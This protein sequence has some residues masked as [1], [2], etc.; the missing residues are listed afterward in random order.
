MA[1]HIGRRTFLA[2]LGGT[3]AWPLAARAQQPAMPVIGFLSGRSPSESAFAVMAFRQGL[4]EAGYVEGRNMHIAFRWAEGR[5]AQLPALAAELVRM[6]IAVIVTTGGTASALAAKA[7]TATIPV[8]FN[9]TVDP[10]QLG[11]VA[12][13]NRPGGNVTGVTNLSGVLTVKRLGLLRDLVPQVSQIA[14]LVNPD[15]PAT[16]TII[17]DIE[18]A[19]RTIGQRLFVLDASSE[20]DLDVVFETLTR[21][22]AGALLVTGEPFFISRREHLV[23]LAARHAIPAIYGVREFVAAGGLMSYGIGTADAYRQMGIYVGRVLKGAK[24]ADL[25]VIQPTKFEF[26][27]NLN[28]AKSLGLTIPPG[29]LAIADEVIE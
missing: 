14:A 5:Y 11:L 4:E 7:A 1:S 3:A 22:K 15:D 21:Q 18:T 17:N 23:A 19:A 12:S 26:V 6:Q 27:I 10:V 16:G 25:P 28:T 2:A 24:P 29:L 8:V 20:H 9:V 13:I